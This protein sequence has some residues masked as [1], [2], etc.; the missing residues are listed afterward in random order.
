VVLIIRPFTK[1]FFF[2]SKWHM[3][4]YILFTKGRKRNLD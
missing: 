3:L 4:P 2:A 1:D